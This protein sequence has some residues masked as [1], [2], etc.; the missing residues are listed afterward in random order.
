LKKREAPK[1]TLT[2]LLKKNVGPK[3]YKRTVKNKH[4]R[5]K[6]S[7]KKLKKRIS[8]T[9]IIEPGKPKKTNKFNKLT[10]KSLGHK[11]LIPLTSVVNLVLNLRPIAST[12]KNELVE[13]NA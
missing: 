3:R 4:K 12:S 8:E 1:S 7:K 11:K 6:R 13:S 10:K 5:G 2:Q 9:N